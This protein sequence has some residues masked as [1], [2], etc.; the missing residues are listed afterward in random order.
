MAILDVGAGDGT[1]IK[2]AASIAATVTGIETS[3]FG[4]NAGRAAGLQVYQHTIA[5]HAGKFAA[6][7]DLVTAFQVLEH[8]ADV[9]EFLGSISK[10]CKPGGTIVLSVPN[11]DSFVGMQSDLPLNMPPHHVGRWNRGSLEALPRYFDWDLLSIDTEPL[12]QAN[13]EWYQ[14]W[15]ESRYLP[16]SRIVRSLYYRAGLG[17]YVKR[18]ISE[19][20]HTILGHTILA[21]FSRRA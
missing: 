16:D 3:P 2:R 10:A 14:S 12:Q 13:L 17:R 20:A 21:T 6:S 4:V 9:K 1:F 5:E 18:F 15:L 19:Q 8:V 7:Y 11:N